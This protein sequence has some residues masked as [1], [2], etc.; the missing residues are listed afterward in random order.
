MYFISYS[1][2]IKKISVLPFTIN[3]ESALY[4]M[5]VKRSPTAA[6]RGKDIHCMPENYGGKNYMYNI[7]V[8]GFV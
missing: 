2:I 8:S 5:T 3:P 7:F 1:H 4:Y 6:V